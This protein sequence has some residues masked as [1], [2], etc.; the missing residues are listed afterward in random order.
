[1]STVSRDLIP[2]PATGLLI[3]NTTTKF[4][5]YFNGG[6]WFKIE[7]SFVSANSG[8]SRP[9]GGVS[10]SALPTKL[11]DSSAMLDASD[12]SRGFLLTRTTPE[13]IPNPDNGLIIY[14]ISANVLK[15]F[16]NGTW[17]Q[18]CGFTTGSSGITGIQNSVGVAISIS[19]AAPDPSAILDVISSSKG[20]LIPRLTNAQ[21]N[22][23][24]P[25]TGLTI[26]NTDSKAIEYYNGSEWFRMNV[27]FN[28]G[29]SITASAL[30]VCSGSSVNFTAFPENGGDPPSYQWKVNGLII[31]GATNSTFS[32]VPVNFDAVTCVMTLSSPCAIGSPAIS[33]T[34]LMTVSPILPVSISISPSVNPV[35]SGSPVTF[36]SSVTN[37]GPAPTFQ[38]KLNGFPIS[39]ATGA[40]Y[41]FVPASTGVYTCT[42]TSNAT[43]TSGNPATSGPVTLTVT[44]N[45]TA[46]VS[47]AASAN[48]V[49]AGT[50]VTY[51]ATN[52]S[53]GG[54]TPGYQWKV[55][56]INAGLNSTTFSYN[57]V[58]NDVITCVMTSS[59]S[60]VTGSP[61][62]SNAVTMTVNPLLPASVSIAAVPSGPVCTGT[63][64]TFTA[65]P[66]FGG[67]GP[68]YQ[69]K[70]GANPIAG[71]TNA[72]YTSATLSNGA[73]ITVVMTSNATPCLTGSP[74]TSNL[75]TM[76]VYPVTSVNLVA[77]ETYCNG[78]TTLA[79]VF[80]SPVSGT[81]YAWTNNTPAIGLA[82]NGTGNIPSFTAANPGT[83]PVIAT[84][85]VTP[86]ANGC[87]GI[88]LS[89]TITINPTPT[90][91]TVT[92]PSYCNGAT[93]SAITFGSPVSGAT[94]TWANNNPSI[95]LA[96]NGTGIVPVFTATNPGTAPEIATITVTPTANGC[97]GTPRSFTITVNP[98]TTVFTVGN[99]DYCNGAT[100]LAITFGSPV[101][102]T[103]YAWVN[104]T[105][106]IGLAANGTGNI[107]V[108]TATNPGT[109]PVIATITVTPTA[110]GCTGTPLSFTITVNPTATVNA[111]GNAAYCNG[112]TTPVITFSSPVAG[113]TYAWANS[114][115]S[116]G[117]AA[118]GTGNIPAFTATNPGT[119]PE[120][121]TITVTPTANGCIGTP[122]SFTITV[123][124]T[125][126]VFAVGNADYCNGASTLA[127]TFG[128]PVA[129]TTYAWVNNT[130]SIGLA[131]NGTGNIPVF[132]AT[133]SGTSTVIAAITV[134]PTANGCT[135]TTLTF[136][137]TV[138]PTTTVFAVSDATYCNGAA[139]SAITFGS[140]VAGT[141]YTWAN[142][143]PSIGLAANGTGNIPSF[144]ATNTG[145]APE[146]ASITV[147]PAANGCTGT[148]RSFTITV[149]PTTTVFPVGN[150]AHCNGATTAAITLSS[151]VAGTTYAWVNNTPSI[152]L[153]ANGNGN[154]PVFT[155]TNTGTAPVVASITVTPTANGCTGIPISFTITVNP[156]ST[157]YQVSDAVYC[158]GVSAAAITFG[159]PVAGTTYTWANNNPSIGLAA[160]GTGNITSFTTTNS[161][162][163]PEIATVT[164]TPAANGCT[165]TPSSFTITVNPTATVFPVSNEAYCN[166]AATAAITFGSPVSGTT[167]AWVN[168]TPS[169]GLAPNGTGNIPVFTATNTG[170]APEVA[171]IT[172][173]PTANSCTGTPLS[174]SITVNPTATVY[175][176]NNTAYCN[177]ATTA[178][179]IFGSPVLGTTYA[180][181]NNNPSIGL[182]A[183]GTGN[184]PSFTATNTGTAPEVATITVTPTANG[185][186][187]TPLSFTIT[188]N[189]TTTVFAV[190]NETYCNGATTAAITFSSPVAGT[191]YTWS[192]NTL[193]IGL[194]ASGTGNLP[195]FTATNS[196]TAPVIATITVTP[197][198]N[199]CTGIPSSFTITVYPTATV[200]PVSNETYCNGAT[201]TLVTLGSPVAGTTYAWTNS[202]PSIGLAASGTGNIPVFSATNTGTAPVVATI[203]I[204]PTANGCTGT[205]SSFTITI[206][207]TATVN[208]VNDAVYCNGAL[209]T[210]VTLGSPVAGTTYAWTNN[211]PSIGLAAS[212]T[213]N[214]PVFTATNPGTAPVVATIT[215]TPTANGCTGIP[216][217]FTITVNPT[218]TVNT[219][220][221]VV[222]CNGATA[223]AITFGSPVAGTT[224][225]WT[226]SNATIGLA[227]TGTGNIASFTATNTG[228]APVIATI[229]VT[230][231]ANNC[232][233]TPLSFTITVN[234]SL[235]ASIV[236][237]PSA[238]NV[239]A[240]TSVTFSTAIVN[241]GS[242]PLYQWKLNN[243]N[244][245]GATNATYT[246]VPLNTQV[247][248]CVLTSNATCVTLSP[249]TSNLVTMTVVPLVPVRA[250][251]VASLYAVM[252]GTSVTFTASVENGGTSPVYQWKVNNVAVGTNSSTYTYTPLNNDKVNCVITSNSTTYCLSNN[253]ATS[254]R[255]SMI[256]YVTGT[257]C[258]GL[259]TVLFDGITYNTVQIGSQCWL[260]ENINSGT[261]IPITTAQTNNAILEKYCYN[262]S[263][264]NCSMYG[265]LY[266]WNEMMQYVT[267]PGTQGICPTG[268]HIP[269]E[270]DFITLATTAGG[271]AVAGG[272]LKEAGF[273]HFRSPNTG[274]TNEFGFT[275][276]P[277]GS[278]FNNA[279]SIFY[280]NIYQTGYF[281]TSTDYPSPNG[282]VFRTVSLS[283]ASFGSYYNLKS[284]G[285][286]VRC[287]KN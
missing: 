239:C 37:G 27:M 70:N 118:N 262:D 139:A 88:P 77:N 238:N 211:T 35:C 89:F 73:A 115:P 186:T 76:T 158:N 176:V 166:G 107:P 172:V 175:P 58:N 276:L 94:Y 261:K 69:W 144:T 25:A 237:T 44:P 29:I 78:A 244:I 50:L 283:V 163:A 259:P 167:Y 224:F 206:Y 5:N 129:G 104:N 53:G 124:P 33:N 42:V 273:G 168:N 225:T 149:N 81:T 217:T 63:S 113:T 185:C 285:N 65:T 9:G 209:T 80:S 109:A 222:Y 202:T 47:I 99:A 281:H 181:A 17:Y 66:V 75:I 136:D 138:Y 8:S 198:A 24:A 192:N 87:T 214:I 267:T 92:S 83:A 204:T 119:A 218:A 23:I 251:I 117:L 190:S 16:S 184:L 268:W 34:M 174:F 205:P 13:S 274:A 114:N 233:G 280:T 31:S 215:I 279:G 108:F 208:A 154:I 200:F 207:P 102:G 21:R 231:T 64:V 134:T 170:T 242:T 48:P 103:T 147:I 127:I 162:T 249:A 252:P 272:K 120:I 15:Y 146:I 159:S 71:A 263:L 219:V 39:G 46:V 40:A 253:P 19:N 197:A 55:N 132:T 247:I 275:A 248:S 287:L 57:P 240:G 131:A 228:A 100:T 10:V 250:G 226:N 43:C 199:G 182:A 173:T 223:A 97:I 128:S 112:A 84:I 14:D 52:V 229:T 122:R 28:A 156:T 51:T 91:N 125:T 179:V 41:T 278:S 101:A 72:S 227:A 2:S 193:S 196:G 241:G 135:G 148:P 165:G 257:A 246:Y 130:P 82:A 67:A 236:V 157:V 169:I 79:I 54:T 45:P 153:A 188:V 133:N 116:V 96:A 98:T 180:W 194:E 155:A 277:T 151:P 106:S 93:T 254:N 255:L 26:F 210:L 38:W 164:V 234:Q 258:A 110:N 1:M 62:T 49:C 68:L 266:Q 137:I 4:F 160:N 59:L 152:G 282:P 36:S 11:P 142:N 216:S 30:S 18:L 260:R 201:T 232:T 286:P 189:P 90:V 12:P 178:T 191:T 7:G 270:A 171:N 256:V 161:G 269:T 203:G 111:V 143:N 22:L 145:T 183:N 123:N 212:G 235:P 264:I 74:A 85:T 213:G 32:Y 195:V 6:A 61:A 121:A 265:G 187:G 150:E 221:N 20:V 126:T 245:T 230:P 3:Y 95:G 105:P 220:S 86:T 140:P 56:N 284:T 60:C 141:T 243:V 271:V 177:E